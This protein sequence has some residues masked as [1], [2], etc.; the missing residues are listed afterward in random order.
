[1]GVVCCAW[2]AFDFDLVMQKKLGASPV[3]DSQFH[4]F[5][6]LK[7]NGGSPLRWSVK[8]KAVKAK[9]LVE[10]NCHAFFNYAQQTYVIIEYDASIG[11][12]FLKKSIFS[13]H[14][15]LFSIFGAEAWAAQFIF[16]ALLP[17]TGMVI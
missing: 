10:R 7:T 1:M 5:N 16:N 17:S 12:F 11:L 6:F 8:V 13:A 14:S 9:P 3:R 2:C 15:Q 4:S